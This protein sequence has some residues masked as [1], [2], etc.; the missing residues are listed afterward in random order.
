MA[1]SDESASLDASR[2]NN[3]TIASNFTGVSSDKK[4]HIDSGAS[5]HLT[6]DNDYFTDDLMEC[7]QKFV[8]TADGPKMEV[9]G[10]GGIYCY[11]VLNGFKKT[12]TLRNVQYVHALKCNLI[13]MNCIRKHG[14]CVTFDTHNNTGTCIVR[15]QKMGSIP[16]SGCE[17]RSGLYE[18]VLYPATRWNALRDTYNYSKSFISDQRL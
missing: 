8:E 5:A 17:D 13:S 14:Y 3:A 11:S 4:W 1:C 10:V 18:I 2:L 16:L 6:N 7:N 15:N 9:K 12:V